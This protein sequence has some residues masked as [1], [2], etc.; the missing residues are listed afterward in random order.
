MEELK[1]LLTP[2]LAWDKLLLFIVV[3][4][5][6][7]IQEV[8]SVL[9][10]WRLYLINQFLLWL[11]TLG[12]LN[13]LRNLLYIFGEV[14]LWYQ[15]HLKKIS[16]LIINVCRA[17]RVHVRMP[18]TSNSF[19]CA[20]LLGD[21]LELTIKEFKVLLW[22]QVLLYSKFIGDILSWWFLWIKISTN[23]FR[24]FY[25]L[26]LIIR[27]KIFF[28]YLLLNCLFLLGIFSLIHPAL[29]NANSIIQRCNFGPFLL[30]GH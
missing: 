1:V 5:L 17:C 9:V 12:V 25:T 14:L 11:L 15:H 6:F 18:L 19:T 29:S 4:C 7:L 20:F 10:F 24:W 28:N 23:S 3:I 16:L 13:L 21:P 2:L 22:I 8:C 27:W 30:Y 26:S